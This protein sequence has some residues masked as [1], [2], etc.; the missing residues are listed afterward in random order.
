MRSVINKL[1]NKKFFFSIFSL[2][3]Y[4]RVKE[5]KLKIFLKK[6]LKFNDN[7]IVIIYFY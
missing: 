1:K 6:V 4:Y 3:R 2:E 5:F 7:N